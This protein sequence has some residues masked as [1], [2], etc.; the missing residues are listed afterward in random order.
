M[1]DEILDLLADAVTDG[2][3]AGAGDQT[4][5]VLRIQADSQ[6]HGEEGDF[7]LDHRFAQFGAVGRF[8]RLGD[9]SAVAEEDDGSLPAL[10]D[11]ETRDR[12]AQRLLQGDRAEGQFLGE[13]G[14]DGFERL[15]ALEAAREVFGLEVGGPDAEAVVGA[16]FLA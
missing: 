11:L 14:D 7:L 3:A 8:Q 10:L 6:R 5:Q 12:L 9:A 13:I 16:E 1:N 2:L 15:A 4:V